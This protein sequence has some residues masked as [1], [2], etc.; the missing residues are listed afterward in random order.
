MS[1]KGGHY[2]ALFSIHGLVRG[3]R[4]ELGRDADTGGQ[5]LYLV[6]LAKALA[7]HSDVQRV[8]LFT[9]RIFDA[10]IDDDYAKPVE[11]L[12]DRANIVRIK[13]GPRRYL[14]KESLWPYLGNFVD[15]CL[16]FWRALGQAPDL[17]H[18]H[19]ADAGFICSRLA[20]LLGIPMAFTGHSL[21]RVKRQR[22]MAQGTPSDAIEKR[23]L[24]AQRIEAEEIALDNAAFVMVSTHQE[25]EEQ[26]K[27]YDNYQ[28]QRMNVAPPGVN[29]HRFSP[30]GRT[31]NRESA[32]YRELSRFLR[33]MNKPMILAI[34][35]PDPRKNIMTLLHAYGQ[36]QALR[37]A[38]N[39]VLVAGTRDDIREME[40]ETQSQLSQIFKTIDLYDLYGQIA[41]PK[42]HAAD[43]VPEMYRLAAKTGGV[44]VN[45]ALTEPFGLTLIEAAASGLPIVATEDGGPRDIIAAC[46]NGVLIDPLKVDELSAAILDAISDR[47][48]WKRWS[49]SGLTGAHCHF[50][51]EAHVKKYVRLANRTITPKQKRKIQ[52]PG[53]NP[54]ITADRVILCDIDN[55]LTGDRAALRELFAQIRDAGN[56]LV[57]G[58]ATGRSLELTLQVLRE[59][60]IPVPTILITSVGTEIYYGPHL[61]QDKQWKDQINYRWEPDRIRKEMKTIPGLI[62]Q[63]PQGQR[64]HKISYD[65]DSDKAPKIKEIVQH[66]RRANLHVN[67]VYSHYA[68]LDLLPVRASKGTA[69]RYVSMR[70]DIPP[71]RILVAGD[72]GNDE[73]MLT[74]N[75]LAVVVGNHS[76]ELRKL[77]N[78]PQIYFAK[79]HH[80]KGIL[81][82][83]AFYE[84][85]GNI[86]IPN[87]DASENEESTP[88]ISA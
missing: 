61:V 88:T 54:L 50:S 76:R 85:L 66:L 75:T 20:G 37:D 51:W 65:V 53:Q 72:S 33:N 35:R 45:P 23:Y 87:R 80:A 36:N 47:A 25:V 59:W 22:L 74:G 55:T 7:A 32:I 69:A 28:P 73:E 86:K 68:Y 9:R 34:C 31:I 39:L 12:A 16:R 38:A 29:L 71:D 14:R 41:Y 44:F 58:I 48:R 67:P 21:G 3:T 6:E 18:G 11:R 83:I 79:G 52:D 15:N 19:Y 1:E 17:I 49:R 81:E 56:K 57:W 27:L 30:P 70:W 77:K 42:Q 64:D 2:I 43:D 5:I 8:D 4:L 84:F 63:G 46:K 10:K 78:R 82:G 60:K 62:P 26:Y 13:C 24:I 40:K